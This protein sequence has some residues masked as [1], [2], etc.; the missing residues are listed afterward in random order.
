LQA[1]IAN[2]TQLRAMRPAQLDISAVR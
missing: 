2:V 1:V